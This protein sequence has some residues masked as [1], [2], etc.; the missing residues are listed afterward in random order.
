[1]AM[2]SYAAALNGNDST[3]LGPIQRLLGSSVSLSAI[4]SSGILNANLNV[5]S[6]LN[7]LQAQLGLGSTT[8]VLAA[9]V[10]AAQVLQAEETA[11]YNQ[12]LLQSQGFLQG[13]NITGTSAISVSNLLGITQGG[14]S[15]LGATLNPLDLAMAT[16]QLA[17]GSNPVALSATSSNLTGLSLSA[18]IGS[19]PTLVCLGW[20]AK[21]M[22]QTSV[23]ASANINSPASLTSA[24]TNLASGLTG[25]LNGVLGLLGGL[26][27]A[28]TY[29]VPTVTLGPVSASVSL[30]NA[31]GT[32]TALNCLGA[33]PKSITAL[34]SSSLAQAYVS[35][36]VIIKESRTY[37]PLWNRQTEYVTS[38]MTVT[39]S[40]PQAT[41][42]QTATLN[43][44]SD[45]PKGQ[46]GPANN[47]NLNNASTTVALQTDGTFSN[48][49]PLI[50]K[51]LSSVSAVTSQ[52]Q[53]TVVSPLL[54]T[55]ATPLLNTLTSTLQTAVG[56]TI[57]GTT[58]TP[59]PT[60]SCG[61]PAL[62]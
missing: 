29:G 55:V 24:V 2:D 28:D 57:A 31:S 4:S 9:N 12:G 34:E 14:N 1:M 62:G 13:L 19:R 20:G 27:G 5:L 44:P 6:F 52:I 58:Y 39:V 45:Y 40:I 18:T 8:Q 43:W 38:T 16:A 37:G 32:V 60:P 41:A 49:Y 15:A 54:S 42:S 33:T 53:S 35:I 36:P 51:M 21:T 30:A 17:N 23:T 61:L 25:L 48:G 47:L 3:V 56:T 26:L 7:V 22:N 59:L 10:T 11:L 46:P 50:N